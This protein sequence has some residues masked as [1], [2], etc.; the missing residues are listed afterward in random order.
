MSK[1]FQEMTPT[2]QGTIWRSRKE[3]KTKPF[4]DRKIQ[5][6]HFR[7]SDLVKDTIKRIFVQIK[8]A[9][10]RYFGCFGN[11]TWGE[12]KTSF[13]AAEKRIKVAQRRCRRRDKA[14]KSVV[15]EIFEARSEASRGTKSQNI[16]RSARRKEV[17]AIASKLQFSATV[18]P[19]AMPTHRAAVSA[20]LTKRPTEV[21]MLQTAKSGPLQTTTGHIAQ[22]NDKPRDRD[23]LEEPGADKGRIS[24]TAT[25]SSS[26]TGNKLSPLSSGS[27]AHVNPSEILPVWAHWYKPP[28][29]TTQVEHMTKRMRLP[30]EYLSMGPMQSRKAVSDDLSAAVTSMCQTFNQT[31]Q[32]HWEKEVKLKKRF[33]RPRTTAV[34]RR[35]S[36]P[37]P[38]EARNADNLPSRGKKHLAGTECGDMTGLNVERQPAVFGSYRDRPLLPMTTYF[39]SSSLSKRTAKSD[40]PSHKRRKISRSSS[41]HVHLGPHGDVAGGSHGTAHIPQRNKPEHLQKDLS[42]LS[43]SSMAL[44]EGIIRPSFSSKGKT[45]IPP[46]RESERHQD[47]EKEAE[48]E[49]PVVN[50]PADT[51]MATDLRAYSQ[52]PGSY[53]PR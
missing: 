46:E 21:Q 45:A 22:S 14:F 8:L 11:R 51:D 12:T 4:I 10:R 3:K 40:R 5:V 19:E 30:E 48:S 49:K 16:A 26:K 27:T 9:R 2:T 33:L 41:R 34:N 35:K 1:A 37:G 15:Q 52:W 38:V 36:L 20:S 7:R 6:R 28:L 44:G 18:N 50:I 25:A 31:F 32:I 13:A 47:A 23:Y 39:D 42:G 17:R 43:N 24:D 29:S 53:E